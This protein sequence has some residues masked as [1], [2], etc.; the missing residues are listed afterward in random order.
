MNIKAMRIPWES[1]PSEGV[2]PSESPTV[3]TAEAVSNRQADRGSFSTALITKPPPKNRVRYMKQTVEALHTAL[4]SI[5]R[6]KKWGSLRRWNTAM[7]L[8]NST[9]AV[10]V[11]IPPAVDPGEPPISMS[12]MVSPCPTPERAV[13]SAVL[14]PAV[15]GVTDWNK[16]ASSRSLPDRAENSPK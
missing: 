11:F 14:K 10:V 3:P 9:A 6:P 1:S 4:L 12:M 16:E 5:R 7:A 13:R 15:R 8:A 2:N